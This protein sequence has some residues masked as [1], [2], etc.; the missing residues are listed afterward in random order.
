MKKIVVSFLFIVIFSTLI[1]SG[2]YFYSLFGKSSKMPGPMFL[3]DHANEYC[4]H[5]GWHLPTTGQ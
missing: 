4:V 5:R 3:W 2:F 1:A